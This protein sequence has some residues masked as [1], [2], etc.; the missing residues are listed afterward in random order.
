MPG[1]L[2]TPAGREQSGS[3]SKPRELSADREG[4]S[5]ALT[6]VSDGCH[7]RW[8]IPV[9]GLRHHG[10][11]RLLLFP[12]AG[13]GASAFNGWQ[14]QF[15]EW[16]ET[17]AV[18]Y[19]GRESRWGEARLQSLAELA[20][21]IADQLVPRVATPFAFLGHSMGG[22]VA[23]EV[24]R[25]LHHR[26]QPVPAHLFLAA[27]RAPRLGCETQMHHLPDPQFISR[28]KTYG[29]LPRQILENEEFLKLLLPILKDDFRLYEQHVRE[30]GQ[31]LPIPITTIGGL[32]DDKV[33]PPDLLAWSSETS[34]VYNNRL[35]PGRHFFLWDS[36]SEVAGVILEELRGSVTPVPAD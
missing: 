3:N 26:G 10:S 6:A 31:A 23:F 9:I 30:P 11:F 34:A 20:A 18:Q 36:P 7:E 21:A 25:L 33:R 1:R 13:G 32:D 15:P 19:P 5:R 24:A 22:L 2:D 14:S 8:T 17:Y 35:L 16:V 27:V 29:G 12:Y 28:L 4:D